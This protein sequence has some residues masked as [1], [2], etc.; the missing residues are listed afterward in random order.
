MTWRPLSP[1]P[2]EREPRAVNESLARI[3]ANLGLAHPDVLGAVF[4]HWEDLVGIDVAGHAT[5]VS[6]RNGVLTVSVDHPAWATSLRML[7]GDLVRRIAAVT[8]VDA[9][10]EVVVRVE[11]TAP[12]SSRKGRT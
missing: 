5:P 10:G 9:V 11:G 8:G 4:G 1:P 3:A 7:A 2:S 6:L 12:R